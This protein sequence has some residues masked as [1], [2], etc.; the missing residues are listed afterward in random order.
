M[1]KRIVQFG[2][3]R[4]QTAGYQVLMNAANVFRLDG[5]CTGANSF[6]QLH[7]AKAAPATNDV[8]KK[9][10]QVFGNDGFTYVLNGKDEVEFA[11]GIY[12]ALSSDE[13]KYVADVSGTKVSGDMEMDDS[14][15]YSGFTRTVV[16]DN[17][18]AVASLQVWADTNSPTKA[19][20]RLELTNNNAAA[21]VFCVVARNAATAGAKV[22]WNSG[23]VAAAASVDEVFGT[24]GL[25]P[26]E[27]TSAGVVWQGCF[28]CAVLASVVTSA[29][30]GIPGGGLPVAIATTD[31]TIRATYKV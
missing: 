11:N 7:D 13:T 31:F 15:A 10:L 5:Y 4:A 18:T 2:A 3:S 1:L 12:L 20:Q 24:N 19:L 27:K 22:L 23:S 8:P 21:V 6:L 30:S 28:V 29:G 16:G 9:S 14:Q 25:T 26:F 17:T